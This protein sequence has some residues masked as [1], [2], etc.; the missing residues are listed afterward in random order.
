VIRKLA[1]LPVIVLTLSLVVPL[2]CAINPVT[3]HREL[4]L[5]SE[6]QEIDTGRKH[7]GPSRQ[8]QG[9]D[10]TIDRDLTTYVASVGRKLAAVSDRRLPYEFAVLNN[11]TPNAWALPGGKLAIN[12]GLL[13]ELKNEAELAAVLG[14]EIV[15][16]AARHGA[17]NIERSRLM[18]GALI[19]TGV[20]LA[21][22]G[23]AREIIGGAQL[24]AT[25]VS[26][27]YSRDD[28][29][30]ADRFGMTYMSRAGY[31]PRAAI[32]LQETFVRLSKG[33]HQDWLT[34]L[35]ASHPPSQDR[36]E[37][38]RETVR[39]LAPRGELGTE[40]YQKAIAGLRKTKEAY[41][42]HDEGRIALQTGE[43]AQARE[44]ARKALAIEPREARFYAL[45]GD[46]DFSEKQYRRA[47]ENYNKA[48]ERDDTFFYFYLQRGLAR[49]QLDDRR[50]ARGDLERSI[51]LLPTAIAHN[52]LGNLALAEGNRLA[53]VNYF[54]S[55][56]DSRSE[57][58]RQAE[59]SLV[60]LDL[61][62]NPNA[63]L[64]AELLIDDEGRILAGIINRTSLVL[65]GIHIRIQYRGADGRIR[66]VI[67]RLP[68]PIRPGGK[69]QVYT[70]IGP[71]SDAKVL[72]AMHATVSEA[73]VIE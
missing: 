49:K 60:R 42:A 62:E 22:H 5:V 41:D 50:G 31:D 10:Y 18:Q 21:D 17:K 11:S 14:H 27:K 16:A 36:V 47:L 20:A 52:A 59:R 24:A 33:D 43:P 70:G 19:V 65:G 9:G 72:D 28:E 23:H 44:L 51:D 69:S 63:Y 46:A 68:G 61:P 45:A 35:F 32:G 37:A 67:K 1:I 71:V 53:A 58:G 30:E 6:S 55:A 7:Y 66:Q 3:G 26:Q 64:K 34:G 38:N 13:L 15:H 25:L 40:A 54:R 39:I 12:R 29:R 56:A 2:G 57:S 48:L 8:M 4:A 73:T